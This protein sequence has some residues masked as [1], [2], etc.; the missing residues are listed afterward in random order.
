MAAAIAKSRQAL[1]ARRRF[2][3]LI[4]RGFEGE[5]H[6]LADVRFVVDDQQRH[7]RAPDSAVGTSTR[8]LTSGRGGSLATGR[9]NVKVDPRP[10]SD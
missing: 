6:H 3:D 7:A 1:F 9:V 8:R 2:V 4:P 10:S 5:P